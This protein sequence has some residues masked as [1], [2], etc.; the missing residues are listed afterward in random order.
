MPQITLAMSTLPLA[1]LALVLSAPL[2]AQEFETERLVGIQDVF[3][4]FF[5]NTVT[6]YGPWLFVAAHNE[7]SGAVTH[8]PNAGII[9]VYHRSSQGWERTQT[10]RPSSFTA[11][12]F[13][14]RMDAADGV[15]VVGDPFDR[16][17]VGKAFVYELSNGH[18]SLAQELIT[19]DSDPGQRFGNEVAISDNRIVVSGWGDDS[20]GFPWG[21][22]GRVRV[23]ERGP[24]EWVETAVLYPAQNPGT[25]FEPMNFGNRLGLSGD[26]LAVSSKGQTNHVQTFVFA[27]G[28][29][30]HRQ[31]LSRSNISN[32]SNYGNA[33]AMDGDWLAVGEP[34]SIHAWPARTGK[35]SIYRASA[36]NPGYWDLRQV[37]QASNA[38]IPVGWNTDSFGFSLDMDG[39]KLAVGARS[40]AA[41]TSN[42]QGQAY[43]FELDPTTQ[44]WQETS[45]LSSRTA[46]TDAV[47]EPALG[48]DV[49]VSDFI[50]AAGARYDLGASGAVQSGAAYVYEQAK[51]DS[52]CPGMINSS[53]IGAELEITGVTLA[54]I[55]ALTARASQVSASGLGLLLTSQVSS[56]PSTPIG[57]EGVLCL[58]GSLVRLL[59]TLGQAT[60]AGLWQAP[61]DLPQSGITVQPGSTW[62][63]Q[64]WYRDLN[65]GP[66]SNFTNMVSV[67]WE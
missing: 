56:G 20:L 10:I 35:V 19:S 9:H 29:W 48:Y 51:G 66:V 7:E 1:L 25:G 21:P 62:H 61:L 65:P 27:N 59:H 15:L 26:R 45:R 31:W 17:N 23:F 60:P 6:T 49:A 22:N 63:F 40:A 50:V 47:T 44:L 42:P 12:L 11:S 57:S 52:S 67:T 64:L 14:N 34:A 43:L 53:G 13:G 55:N 2:P 33:L 18:W 46:E 54:N 16:W 5:G 4:D 24:L 8:W 36:V 41:G 32:H 3:Q 28:T 38:S 37:L 58:G 30:Q 39:G